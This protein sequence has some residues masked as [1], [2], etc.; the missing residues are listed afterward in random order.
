VNILERTGPSSE[1]AADA[2]GDAARITAVDDQLTVALVAEAAA[3]AWAIVA[4]NG[5]VDVA[6]APALREALDAASGFGAR[7]ILDLSGVSF[8]DST[9]LTEL[10]RAHKRLIAAGGE[11]RMVIV[12]DRLRKLFGITKLDQIFATFPTVA[13]AQE[14]P[15][16][17]K[18]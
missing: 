5:E 3:G 8:M 10:I 1:D 14:G 12:G 4:A 18:N 13:S 9:G 17:P 2:T 15:V 6:T 16:A 11:L 7:V